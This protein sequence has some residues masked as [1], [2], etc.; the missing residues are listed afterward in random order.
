MPC[1][2]CCRTSATPPGPALR[3]PGDFVEFPSQVNE[4][5]AYEP[6]PIRRFARHHV[7]GEALPTSSLETLIASRQGTGEHTLELLQ[8]MVV[9]QAW[10]QSPLEEL[11]E[12]G[13]GVEAFEAA[14]LARAGI[15]VPLIAP[16]YRS[17]YFHHVFGGGYAAGYYSYLWSEVMDADT[18]AWFRD[19]GT[20]EQ[21]AGMTRAAGE[22]F[23][24]ELLARGGSVDAMETYRRFR[25]ADPDVSHLLARIGLSG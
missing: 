2:V 21:P 18:V 1:T 23:R 20:V 11:P 8:A 4:I 22:R 6:G 16:R 9:D 17:A 3:C 5:W 25:G 12:D 19:Q 10:H 7:T 13:W 24:R 14:A 15:D